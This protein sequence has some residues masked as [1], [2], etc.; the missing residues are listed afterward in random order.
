MVSMLKWSSFLF[1]R[2]NASIRGKEKI[3]VTGRISRFAGEI[4]SLKV[5]NYFGILE[6]LSIK[7]ANVKDWEEEKKKYAMAGM[8]TKKFRVE[9]KI[10]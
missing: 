8:R 3:H 5:R 1:R 2:T 6:S 9:E 10:S 4:S 7:R